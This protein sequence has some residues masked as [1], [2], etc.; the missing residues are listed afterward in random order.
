MGLIFAG[1]DGSMSDSGDD[2]VTKKAL[3]MTSET[4]IGGVP[5]VISGFRYPGGPSS[6][7]TTLTDAQLTEAYKDWRTHYVTADGA[8]GALRVKRDLA[9]SYDTVSEGIAYGMLLAVYFDDKDTFDGLYRYSQMHLASAIDDTEI[10]TIE[11][12]LMHWKVKADNTDI[13]E[14]R[15]KIP[16]GIVY[17]KKS[18]YTFNDIDESDPTR[19]R[20]YYVDEDDDRDKYGDS[21]KA[22][23]VKN[24]ATNTDYLQSTVFT[25][26]L[27]SATDADVDIAGA[28]CLAVKRW[29]NYKNAKT[30]DY[31]YEAAKNIRNIIEFDV[32]KG[33]VILGNGT[34]WGSKFCWNPSYFTPAWWR[35]YAKFIKDNETNKAFTENIYTSAGSDGK[36]YIKDGQGATYYV[37]MC[38]TIL[39]NMYAE[40]A[41]IDKTNGTAGLYPDWCDTSSAGGN[42]KKCSSWDNA[43]DRRY[44]LDENLDGKI[45]GKIPDDPQWGSMENGSDGDSYNMLSFNFYYD[46]V[47]VPWRLAHDYIWYKNITAESMIL[48]TADFF[49]DK[50]NP[51]NTEY[52]VDGYT[53]AGGPW[54]R[55][56]RDGFNNTAKDDAGIFKDGGRYHSPSFGSMLGIPA[57]VSGIPGYGQFFYDFIVRTPEKYTEPNNYYGNTLRLI[58]FLHMSGKF[59]NF[60]DFSNWNFGSKPIDKSVIGPLTVDMAYAD[61]GVYGT[62]YLSFND[63]AKLFNN[64]QTGFSKIGSGVRGSAGSGKMIIGNNSYVGDVACGLKALEF[65]GTMTARDIIAREKISGVVTNYGFKLKNLNKDPGCLLFSVDASKFT[66]SSDNR[67]VEPGNSITLTPGNYGSLSLKGRNSVTFSSGVYHFSSVIGEPDVTYYF[68]TTN[69]PVQIFVKGDFSMKS[70]SKMLQKGTSKGADPSKILVVVNSSNSVYIAST[71]NWRGTLIAPNTSE[72]IIDMG[73]SSIIPKLLTTPNPTKWETTTAGGEAYGAFW[74]KNVTVHQDTAVYNVPYEWRVIKKI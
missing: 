58:S 35:L 28:L 38:D 65:R 66:P 14:F 4:G 16:H 56:D 21:H 45:D 41:K 11:T 23:Q 10:Y 20:M 51:S 15:L 6:V 70:R 67:N 43:S 47:R 64:D 22:S 32:K 27:G 46:G 24:I 68:D 34:L 61:Y 9:S 18:E 40:M 3:A 37:N 69:G 73:N 7:E 44:Y 60:Y 74:G 2:D 63:R 36:T 1:C 29:Q 13:S 50:I 26:K 57:L 17:M 5:G 49:L 55:A 8:G 53:I 30:Y 33:G 71:V 52:F 42:A 59:I 19:T 62:N 25:R 48:E 31:V 12:G 72:L 54:R 39:K